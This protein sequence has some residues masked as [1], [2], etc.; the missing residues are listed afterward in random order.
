MCVLLSTVCTTMCLAIERLHCRG[1][2]MSWWGVGKT[3]Q[4]KRQRRHLH[5]QQFKFSI[6]QFKVHSHCLMKQRRPCSAASP[7]TDPSWKSECF[8][9][10]K[11]KNDSVVTFFSILLV[12]ETS[13]PLPLP[14]SSP[15]TMYATPPS[16]WAAVFLWG[17]ELVCVLFAH[18]DHNG[19][20]PHS[21]NSKKKQQNN[22]NQG[23]SLFLTGLGATWVKLQF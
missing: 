13:A 6:Q 22:S 15:E 8:S 2:I 5:G 3:K 16:E 12:I 7:R 20:F 23:I 18:F 17:V 9:W 10:Q 19:T 1:W 21:K 14:H 11:L 4:N